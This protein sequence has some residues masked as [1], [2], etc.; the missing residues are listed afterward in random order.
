MCREVLRACRALCSEWKLAPQDWPAVTECAQS[1]LNQAPLKRLGLRNKNQP[2]VHRTPLEVYT[3]HVPT[4]PLLSALPLERNKN[5]PSLDEV[6]ARQLVNIDLMQAAL[7]D[8]HRDVKL[9]AEKSRQRKVDEHNRKTNVRP[10][11]FNE[12]DFVLVRRAVTK[13]HKL[14]FIWTGPRRIVSVHSDLVYEVEDLLDSKRSTVHAR[15]LQL[16]RADMDGKAVNPKLQRAAEH[17]E[18]TFQ[19][20]KAL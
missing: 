5:L 8:M 20:A 4:R 19:D 9:R 15:R 17:A 2:G 1:V 10:V 13:G 11:N 3:G 14:Q 16:Y 18:A 12:G 6:R 7:E